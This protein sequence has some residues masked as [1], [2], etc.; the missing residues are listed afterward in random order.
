M[1]M[2]ANG[3]KELAQDYLNK[4]VYMLGNLTITVFNSKL[5][6]MSFERKKNVKRCQKIYRL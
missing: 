1:K 2:I 4:Y 6:N 3:Y 5:S